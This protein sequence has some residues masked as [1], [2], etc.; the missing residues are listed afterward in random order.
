MRLESAMIRPPSL[1]LGK[2][3]HHVHALA[4]LLLLSFALTKTV[5]MWQYKM[6]LVIG[7]LSFFFLSFFFPL[8]SMGNY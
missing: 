3:W 7:A 6:I 4:L 8:W 1:E 2:D 5:F